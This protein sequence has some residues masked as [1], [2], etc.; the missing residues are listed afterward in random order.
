MRSAQV[1]PY[2]WLAERY[3][4]VFEGFR[5]PIDRARS[6]IL[7]G[8]V[9][10]AR[11]ACDLACGAGHTAVQ[12]A[13]G[14]MRVYGVDLSAGMCRAARARVK[15]AG[16]PIRILRGDMRTFRLPEQ[17]DL[18]TCE[19]D[20]LNHVP[21]KEDL[22]QVAAAVGRALKPGGHFYF[23][24]NNRKGFQSYWTGAVWI[25]KPGLVLVMRNGNG[26]AQDRA[27]CDLEWFI[28]EGG[29]WRRR[30]ERVEEVCWSEEEIRGTLG[31]LGF[32][33][34]RVRDGSKYFEGNPL[35]KRGCRSIYLARKV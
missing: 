33:R 9:P 32:D 34:I 25:E 17:V 30:R 16:L 21:R 8:I 2:H 12:L 35:M 14:G 3:D 7:A 20:A 22:A 26:A 10:G 23:D 19:Y 4:R 27:W 1:R 11:T 5:A 31:D 29:A 15:A 24:V 28:R 18:V 13:R 6:E